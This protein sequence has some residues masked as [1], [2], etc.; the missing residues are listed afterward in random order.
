MAEAQVRWTGYNQAIGTYQGELDAKTRYMRAFLRQ[1]QRESDYDYSSLEQVLDILIAGA[2]SIS[3]P[4][5][6]RGWQRSIDDAV[7]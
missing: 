2:V 7:D 4:E 1:R 6:S 5:V 3:E